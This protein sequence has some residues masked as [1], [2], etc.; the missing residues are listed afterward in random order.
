[1]TSTYVRYVQDQRIAARQANLLRLD[2]NHLY[3]ADTGNTF[4][5]FVAQPYGSNI[6]G[7]FDRET[8]HQLA[9]H[10]E[11]GAAGVNGAIGMVATDGLGTILLGVF[12]GAKSTLVHEAGHAAFRVLHRASINTT[13]DNDEAFCYLLDNIFSAFERYI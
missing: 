8:F 7:A 6:Y 9:A 4:R 13:V 3:F 2:D 11:I 10:F 12:D 1:M 5:V